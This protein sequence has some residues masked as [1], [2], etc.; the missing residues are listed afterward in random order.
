MHLTLSCENVTLVMAILL[1]DFQQIHYR[2]LHTCQVGSGFLDFQNTAVQ[3]LRNY[4]LRGES[5]AVLSFKS[6]SLRSARRRRLRSGVTK[7][8]IGP[9][10]KSV[11]YIL[12]TEQ[13]LLPK[14]NRS[15]HVARTPRCVN[16]RFHQS[17]TCGS[18]KS[19]AFSL[20]NAGLKATRLQTIR[21]TISCWLSL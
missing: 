4:K 14:K 20:K 12:V 16:L 9:P 6:F 1:P 10:S 3:S 2:K 8:Q 17:Y 13:L 21:Y 15:W 7:A 5:F 19:A 11:T 18:T